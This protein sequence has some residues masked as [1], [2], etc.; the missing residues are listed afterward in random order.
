MNYDESNDGQDTNRPS[1]AL[2]WLLL[3][4]VT[5]LALLAGMALAAGADR[6]VAR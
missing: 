3:A 4:A 6:M 2:K 5:T 1:G